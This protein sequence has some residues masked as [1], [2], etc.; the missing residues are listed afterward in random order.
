M[1][2][3]KENTPKKEEKVETVQMY[4]ETA[5]KKKEFKKHFQTAAKSF[6]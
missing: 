2:S 6:V 5:A 3:I 4:L 1:K